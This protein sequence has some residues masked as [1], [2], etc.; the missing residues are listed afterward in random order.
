MIK[1]YFSKKRKSNKRG[2]Y[3]KVKLCALHGCHNESPN[4]V[5]L[6]YTSKKMN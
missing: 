2:G 1:T 6:I 4:F 3:I 5:Q